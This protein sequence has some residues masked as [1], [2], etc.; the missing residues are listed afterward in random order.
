[1]D[2]SGMNQAEQAHMTKVIEKK[3]MQD[4]LKM[5]S[6]IVEKCFS[7]CC[8]DFTSKALTSKEDTCVTNCA[9]KWLKHSERIGTRFAELNAEM[10]EAQQK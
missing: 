1:M 3:Q 8:N 9:E 4:F 6:N 7:T 2:F 10:M 5:Y